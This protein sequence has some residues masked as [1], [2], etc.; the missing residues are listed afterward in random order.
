MF[1][2]CIM[3]IFHSKIGEYISFHFIFDV[4]R[5]THEHR[6]FIDAVG[7]LPKKNHRSQD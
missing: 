5:I 6:E 1:W 3:I 7:M 4:S 2:Y